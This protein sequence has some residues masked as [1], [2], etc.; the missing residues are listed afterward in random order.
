MGAAEEAVGGDHVACLESSPDRRGR[1]RALEAGHRDERQALDV[2][3]HIR[4]HA[5]EELD[6]ATPVAPEVEVLPH[7]DQP[8]AQAADEHLVDEVFGR[9][10]GPVLVEVEHE[11]V[12]DAR[13]GQPFELLIGVGE[14]LRR[15]LGAHDG[16]RMAV[17]GHDGG[18][19]PQ[20]GSAPANLLDH[21]PVAEMHAVVGADRDRRPRDRHRAG[22]HVAKHFHRGRGYRPT[23]RRLRA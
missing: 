21:R 8:G 15:R 3:T 1:H 17:E 14:Q 2:E 13:N 9:L 20:G 11:R 12:V 5:P 10:V 6:V 7:Y 22:S 18:G 16:C 23:P 19:A 4:A